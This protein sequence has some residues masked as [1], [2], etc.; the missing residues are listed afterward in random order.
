MLIRCD[1]AALANREDSNNQREKLHMTERRDSGHRDAAN[2]EEQ[3][4]KG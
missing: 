3:T 2:D 4:K 1:I